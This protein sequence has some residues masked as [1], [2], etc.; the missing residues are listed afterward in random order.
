LLAYFKRTDFGGRIKE[1]L[2][3]MM[4]KENSNLTAHL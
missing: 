3:K 1:D 2:Q 4:G